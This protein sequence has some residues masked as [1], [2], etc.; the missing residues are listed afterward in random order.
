MVSVSAVVRGIVRENKLL[1]EGIRQE[2]LNYAA[3]AEMIQER[4]EKETGKVKT[5][6]IIM[7][8]RRTAENLANKETEKPFKL[9]SEIIMKTK[10]AYI[11]FSKEPYLLKK[12]ESFYNKLNSSKDT[13]NIIHGNYEISIITNERHHKKIK[14]LLGLKISI[15]Q[16]NLVSLSVTLDKTHMYSP[17]VI[18]AITR[19]LYW[20][21]INIFELLTAATELTFLFQQKDAMKAYNAIQELMKE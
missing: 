15:E 3:V 1:Q 12:L 10:L 20:E 17:G 9:N 19:K 16:S 11:S 5:S 6:A 18:F 2:L 21:G 14:E 8:L 4:V 7:S 13:F